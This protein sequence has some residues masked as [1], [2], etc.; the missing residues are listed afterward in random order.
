M[1]INSAFD[2]INFYKAKSQ[3]FTLSCF[4]AL[5]EFE[6]FIISVLFDLNSLYIFIP[7]KTLALNNNDWIVEIM[8]K[9]VF[10]TCEYKK[11]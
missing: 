10:Q 11:I 1:G 7:E 8:I 9:N 6:V 3:I 4:E 2:Y 5:F